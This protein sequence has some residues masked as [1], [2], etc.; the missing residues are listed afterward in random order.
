MSL[1]NWSNEKWSVMVGLVISISFVCFMGF[2]VFL[3]NI[4]KAKMDEQVVA[5]TA[6][7][8]LNYP[9]M[10][11]RDVECH[12]SFDNGNYYW[13]SFPLNGHTAWALCHVDYGC[14]THYR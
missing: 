8:I 6:K 9:G 1:D 11:I 3:G 5:Q 12:S 4:R 13:C 14:F 7:F 2:G 10:H